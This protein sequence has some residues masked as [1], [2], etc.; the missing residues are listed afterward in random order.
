MR[1][2]E[3][4]VSIANGKQFFTSS[5]DPAPTGAG[6]AFRAMPIQAGIIRVSEMAA[7]GTLIDVSTES[8]SAAAFDGSQ[9]FQMPARNP[10]SAVFNELLSRGADDVGHLQRWSVH[11]CALCGIWVSCCG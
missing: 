7:T 10:V 8:R 3:N 9:D 4:D 6:L 11:L 2:R 5:L 1:H